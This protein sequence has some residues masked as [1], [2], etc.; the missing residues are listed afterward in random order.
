LAVSHFGFVLNFA[1]RISNFR[2]II[3]MRANRK[4]LF[5]FE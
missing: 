1:I 5:A 4:R 3:S 2:Y